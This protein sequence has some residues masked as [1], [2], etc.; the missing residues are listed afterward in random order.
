MLGFFASAAPGSP[1]RVTGELEDAGWFTREQVTSGEVL[2]PPT[3]SISW[4]LIETW[5][6]GRG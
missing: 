6:K 2:A 4:R 5:L 1:V 3:Q